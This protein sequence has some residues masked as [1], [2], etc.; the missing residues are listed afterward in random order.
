MDIL[1]LLSGKG[2]PLETQ[3]QEQLH[4]SIA[5]LS[6][7]CRYLT[8]INHWFQNNYRASMLHSRCS[9]ISLDSFPFCRFAVRLCQQATMLSIINVARLLALT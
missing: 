8:C 9:C 7:T 5:Y 6:A 1:A 3:G 4:I 2:H